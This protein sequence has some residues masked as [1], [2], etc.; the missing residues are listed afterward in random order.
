[1]NSIAL[2]YAAR[3]TGLVSLLLLTGTVILG[4]LGQLRVTAP[5]WPRFVVGG[6]HR[7]VSLLSVAFLVVHIASSVIDRYAGIGWLD[8]IVPFGS[9]YRP[10]WL[11]LGA[12]A[13][14]LVV[15]LVVT[16]LSRRFLGLRTW[17]AVHWLAY[18][19]WPVALVHAWGTGTD[20]AHGWVLALSVGCLLAVA[21]AAITRIVA[22]PRRR[23]P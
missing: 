16:S 10:F 9:V 14:D 22:A 7:N 13:F 1:M 17:R 6:L 21:A 4:I 23:M 11:G 8:A 2:W 3:A 5:N 20:A 12:I 15:A 19:C 18:V